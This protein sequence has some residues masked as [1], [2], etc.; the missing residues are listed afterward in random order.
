MKTLLILSCNNDLGNCCNDPA[1]KSILA[2][3]TNILTIIQIAVPILLL[4]MTAFQLMQMVIN[5]D[6]KIIRAEPDFVKANYAVDNNAN[7]FNKITINKNTER[8]SCQKR[9]NSK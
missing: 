9:I 5:P 4:L 8:R 7:Y 1:I 6:E 2:I 3:I